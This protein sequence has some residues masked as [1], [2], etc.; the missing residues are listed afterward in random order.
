MCADSTPRS[1]SR[2]PERAF[3]G[4]VI[5]GIGIW[6]IASR[7]LGAPCTI[8]VDHQ[9]VVTVESRR[10]AKNVLSEV[11]LKA[12]SLNGSVRFAER[13]TLHN[14]DV[15][16][17]ITEFPEAVKSLEGV[18]TMEAESFAIS[19]DGEAVA[20]LRDKKSA[21]KTLSLVKQHYDG[22]LKDRHSPS[23]FKESVAVERRYVPMQRIF[24]SA[25]EA[26]HFLISPIGEPTVHLLKR[27]DRAIKLAEQYKVTLSEMKKNNP[28][29]DLDRL[30]EGEQLII[31]KARLPITVISKALVTETTT[32]SPPQGAGRSRVGTRV[33]KTMTTFENGVPVSS[34]VISQ[35]TTWGQQSPAQ[36]SVR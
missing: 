17:P 28:G 31:K 30:T 6:V 33:T 7:I 1:R 24:A 23:T 27:G 19:V 11:R 32:I 10:T 14:A 9:P 13:V 12:D 35:V 18:V 2:W 34:E 21:E 3:F 16:V 20:A 25:E 36:R 5:L 29:L 26:F 22:N 15:S 8:T 4:G